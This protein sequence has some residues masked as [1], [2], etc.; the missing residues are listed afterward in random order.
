MGLN[1]SIL[2][3]FVESS[4]LQGAWGSWKQRQ[5]LSHFGNDDFSL[6]PPLKREGNS[7]KSHRDNSDSSV[8]ICSKITFQI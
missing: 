3:A 6:L 2:G 1:D 5:E 4:S 7:K 8:S